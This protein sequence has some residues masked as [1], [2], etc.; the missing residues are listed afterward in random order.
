MVNQFENQVTEMLKQMN[1]C[2]EQGFSKV[3][4]KLDG[5]GGNLKK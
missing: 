5:I 2:M 3:N 1:E 4:E